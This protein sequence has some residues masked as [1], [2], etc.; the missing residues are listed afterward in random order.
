MLKVCVYTTN[1][2]E[3]SKLRPI[4]KLL[5]E[6][7]N[8]ELQL[9][10]T[11]S[12]L[13]K[14]YGESKNQIIKDGINITEEIYT[15]IAGD[16]ISKTVETIGVGLLKLP[17]ILKKYDPDIILCGF[18]RFDMYP[19][20]ITAAL[21]NYC[22]IHIEGGEITG[23]LDEKIRHSITK[24]SNYHFVST[25]QAKTNLIKMG[26][27]PETIFVTGCPRYDELLN[28]PKKN[29]DILEYYNVNKSNFLIFCYHPVSSNINSSCEEWKILLESLVELKIPTI[30][31]KPNIDYG[32][33]QLLELFNE[34]NIINTSYLYVYNHIDIDDFS[35]LLKNCNVL[36]GNSSTG[37]R[38]ACVFGTPVINIGTRQQY[39]IT[40]QLE[41][42]H[43]MIKFTKT[44]LLDKIIFLRY[45]KYEPNLLFGKGNASET[46]LRILKTINYKNTEKV[47][48]YS[49]L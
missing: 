15:H 23:T 9:L 47:I 11:G 28:I 16:D 21:M 10:V 4:L 14:Q 48:S 44:E 17:S 8:I 31:I 33:E 5:Q 26:E 1:R 40:E 41:N 7:S 45:I 25:N 42:V 6:D 20:A 38:E 37:I 12:H 34:L 22:L 2:A 19:F 32:N 30:F 29:N 43:N 27:Y 49:I 18:D 46:I 39:R 35:I 3:Y 24:L 13:L 36:I